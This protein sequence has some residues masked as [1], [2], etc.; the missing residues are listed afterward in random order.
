MSRYRIAPSERGWGPAPQPDRAIAARG[1]SRQQC[2]RR[3]EPQERR[4]IARAEDARRQGALGAECAEARDARAAASRAARRGCRRVRRARGRRWSRSWRLLARCRLCSRAASRSPAWRLARADRIEAELFEER[5][6]ADGGLDSLCLAAGVGNGAPT[7][8]RRPS[9]GNG[10]RSFE[11]LLRYRGAAM[12]EF[13]RALRTLKALQAE[14]ALRAEQTL[15]FQQEVGPMPPWR[16]PRSDPRRSRRWSIIR[17]RTN[18]SATL[19]PDRNDV[20]PEPSR[21]H[22]ARTRRPMAAK[23]SRDQPRA[24]YAGG[25]SHPTKLN[26]APTRTDPRENGS[27]RA[28]LASIRTEPGAR[29]SRRRA[30]RR[31]AGASAPLP[32]KKRFSLVMEDGP[33]AVLK[34]KQTTNTNSARVP[35]RCAGGDAG[36]GSRPPRTLPS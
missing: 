27:R 22:P 8:F 16:R 25:D 11:T 34:D 4:E 18:P 6:S 23:R 2:A 30:T 17:Y 24:A 26:R 33:R 32:R 12:A 29:P 35:D 5:R 14:Q 19:W 36:R 31:P 21:S 20:L 3:G 15:E 28:L 10:P 9:D 13:W 7:P 1:R